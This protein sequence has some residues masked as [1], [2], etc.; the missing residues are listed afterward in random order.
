MSA[1][2]AGLEFKVPSGA[3][4]AL[5]PFRPGSRSAAAADQKSKGNRLQG[6]EHVYAMTPVQLPPSRAETDAWLEAEREALLASQHSHGSTS[7]GKTGEL[8]NCPCLFQR[9]DMACTKLQSPLCFQS[10]VLCYDRSSG[11]QVIRKLT[12]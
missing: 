12:C 5:P 8:T 2:W 6:P 1:V 9:S 3:T 7:K 11:H 4:S 10:T